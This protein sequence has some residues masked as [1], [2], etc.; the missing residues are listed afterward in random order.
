MENSAVYESDQQTTIPMPRMS[1]LHR[2][3]RVQ[4]LTLTYENT[5]GRKEMGKELGG[6]GGEK[7]YFFIVSIFSF[8]SS[9]KICAFFFFFFFS[10]YGQEAGK[11]GMDYGVMLLNH[12]Q[13]I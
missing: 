13:D 11:S 2:F 1:P 4:R 5:G 8:Q 7:G 10:H 6:G 12:L 3:I 9:W